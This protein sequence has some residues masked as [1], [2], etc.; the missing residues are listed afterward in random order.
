MQFKDGPV[1]YFLKRGAT[2]LTVFFAVVMPVQAQTSPALPD[3]L[4][5]QLPIDPFA[6]GMVIDF[7]EEMRN[8]VRTI[9]TNARSFN[10]NFLV[11][12][13]DGLSLV[14][15]INPTDS[16]VH[17][18]AQAYIRALDG[19]L[20]THLLD[21]TVTTPAGKPSPDL[22]EAL[23]LRKAHLATSATY[24]L[25]VL[26]VEYS[27]D[28]NTIDK[29]YTDSG[30]KGFVGFVG[31]APELTS[32]PSH[33][34]SIHS[35]NSSGINATSDMRNYLYIANSKTFG[36]TSNYLQT[37][38]K[39]N[40]D[41]LIIDVFHNGKPLTRADVNSLKYKRLGSRRLVFAEMDISSA[42]VYRY[43][44]KADWRQGNPPY[45]YR[46]HSQD[47]D[48]Y[49]AIYWD[50]GWQAVIAG[51]LQSYLYGILDLGFDGVVLKGVDAWKFYATGGEV[52]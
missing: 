4:A 11:I 34:A 18:P 6:V 25:T 19:V 14:D 41:A 32:I 7:K 24:G 15:K 50:A 33:P 51:D 35:A 39:T 1:R 20:E 29:L 31:E 48:S 22:E 43:Y 2:T 9:S 38:R 5:V 44:W 10:P 40:Y 3:P 17:S 49:R 21:E 28:P 26:N 12:A 47:P 36:A 8:F 45:I 42:A 37:L 27:T 16:S 13:Q 30:T 23:R 46:P 52:E